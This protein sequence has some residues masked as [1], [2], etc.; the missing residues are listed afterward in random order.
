MTTRNPDMTTDTA[1][2]EAQVAQLTNP[3]TLILLDA[4]LCA[5]AAPETLAHEAVLLADLRMTA[6]L[7]EAFAME[8]APVGL[9]D[10]VLA[11][12][13]LESAAIAGRIHAKP[14]VLGGFAEALKRGSWRYAAM[15]SVSFSLGL[16][17]V[18]FVAH[19]ESPT[20]AAS[21]WLARH[22][23]PSDQ[24][25][26]LQVVVLE[27]GISDDAMDSVEQA[28]LVDELQAANE[29]FALAGL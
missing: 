19:R 3:A 7:D 27:T 6:L 21:A 1:A 5:E 23:S 13:P 4:A 12:A 15:V 16:M 25:S 14:S 8:S 24:M 26:R 20:M 29:D 22:T 28:E 11:A 9:A 10:R 2:L 18:S 17:G